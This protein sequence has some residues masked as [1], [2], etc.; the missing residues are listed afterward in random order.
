MN[1]IQPAI[2]AT[3]VLVLGGCAVQRSEIASEAQQKMVGMNTGKVLACMGIPAAKDAQGPTEVWTYNS[4]DGRTVSFAT[5]NAF[6][7]GQS[8]TQGNAFMAGNSG[9]FN[10][11]TYG[12]ANTTAYGMGATRHF[13]CTINVV[14]QNGIVSSVNYSG[15]TGPLIAQKEQCG[16]AVQNCVK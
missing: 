3:L 6:T 10:S 16:Y 7:S 8:T 1:T 12:S 4:G 11:S 9:T 13:S 15:L 5:A 2:V 14:F